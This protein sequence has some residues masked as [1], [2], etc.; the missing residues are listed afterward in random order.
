M[1]DRALSR[2]GSLC[3][4]STGDLCA[5]SGGHHWSPQFV[6]S[7]RSKA[8]RDGYMASGGHEIHCE[9]DGAARQYFWRPLCEEPMVFWAKWG[10]NGFPRLG[11]RPASLL[12]GG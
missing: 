4:T 8:G 11:Y 12:G 2:P 5:T 7:G 9:A 3:R 10:R 1:A 6:E